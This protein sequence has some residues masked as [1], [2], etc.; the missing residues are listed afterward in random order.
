MKGD[1]TLNRRLRAAD[2][3]ARRMTEEQQRHIA[4]APFICGHGFIVERRMNLPIDVIEN[5]PPCRQRLSDPFGI[6]VRDACLAL[7][8][9]ASA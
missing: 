1:K 2:K 4:T 7:L 3:A 8:V 6:D 9:C 5:F